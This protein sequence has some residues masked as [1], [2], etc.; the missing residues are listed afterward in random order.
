[1]GSYRRCARDIGGQCT[2][3][4]A[5]DA[6]RL[7]CLSDGA[8]TSCGLAARSPVAQ[9]PLWP[10]RGA[11]PGAQVPG[12]G[13]GPCAFSHARL[14]PLL[15]S[16]PQEISLR[17]GDLRRRFKM[18]AVGRARR[19]VRSAT[20]AGAPSQPSPRHRRPSR[21]LRR[22]WRFHLTRRIADLAGVRRGRRTHQPRSIGLDRSSRSRLSYDMDEKIAYLQLIQSVITRMARNSFL[23][24]AAA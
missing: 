2:F 23:M 8:A 6:H 10:W 14:R 12:S 7:F 24:P 9:E 22:W 19:F 11:T 4:R 5:G 3:W 18:I 13:A 1:M 16:L 15:G 17:E 21:S 20:G